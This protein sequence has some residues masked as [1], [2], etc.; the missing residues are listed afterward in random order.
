[1]QAACSEMRE[2]GGGRKGTRQESARHRLYGI[3][4][5]GGL[6]G[7]AVMGQRPSLYGA[8]GVPVLAHFCNL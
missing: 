7:S 5:Q 4:Q 6:H 8:K 1:M 2:G 3:K